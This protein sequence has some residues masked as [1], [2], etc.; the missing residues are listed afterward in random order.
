MLQAWPALLPS[1]AAAPHASVALLCLL[2]SI[3]QSR[4]PVQQC[5]GSAHHSCLAGPRAAPP[6]QPAPRELLRRSRR[7][8]VS[9][10]SALHMLPVA[11]SCRSSVASVV[12]A[13]WQAHAAE[14]PQTHFPASNLAAAQLTAQAN[15]LLATRDQGGPTQ[16]E[17]LPAVAAA[18][19]G[20]GGSWGAASLPPRAT[21]GLNNQHA[22]TCW[23]AVFK[24]C[25]EAI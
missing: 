9:L 17:R 11:G 18:G 22:P 12:F 15:A 14:H 13:S 24:P 16:Q 8:S 6:A 4:C 10:L 5:K 7:C 19:K 3:H 20:E 21:D 23:R 25:Q 2:L 1:V